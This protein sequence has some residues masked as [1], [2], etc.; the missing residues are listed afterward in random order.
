MARRKK[1]DTTQEPADNQ[2]LGIAQRVLIAAVE[3]A[4]GNWFVVLWPNGF[5]LASGMILAIGAAITL[6]W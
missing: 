2:G 5:G 3:I 1:P 6:G 4:F